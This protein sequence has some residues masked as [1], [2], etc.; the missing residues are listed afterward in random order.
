LVLGGD[1]KGRKMQRLHVNIN[2]KRKM[3]LEE[4]RSLDYDEGRY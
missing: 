2:N 1:L 4:A 3:T